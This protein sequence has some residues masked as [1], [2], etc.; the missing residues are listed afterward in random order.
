MQFTINIS[1]LLASNPSSLL[2]RTLASSWQRS[3]VVPSGIDSEDDGDS[4]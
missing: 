3:Q 2:F 1:F 4:S